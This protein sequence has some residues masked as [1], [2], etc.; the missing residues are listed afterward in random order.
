[1]QNHIEGFE[2]LKNVHKSFK[3]EIFEQSSSAEMCKKM[4]IFV[5]EY[6]NKRGGIFGAKKVSSKIQKVKSKKKQNP[7]SIKKK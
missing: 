7:K 1:M 4:T 2:D 3:K 6:R 5:A